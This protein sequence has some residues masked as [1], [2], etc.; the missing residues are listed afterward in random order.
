M[1][2]AGRTYI[3]QTLRRLRFDS[4]DQAKSVFQYMI[5]LEE[6]T[7][8]P[9]T[10]NQLYSFIG[11]P[12]KG[13][14]EDHYGWEGLSWDILSNKYGAAYRYDNRTRKGYFV[15]RFPPVKELP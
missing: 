7:G 2:Y 10:V 11:L 3:T 15:V 5:N 12:D 14:T 4:M 1:S 6:E 13:E 8:K 9:V